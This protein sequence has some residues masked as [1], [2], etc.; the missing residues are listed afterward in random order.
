[1]CAEAPSWQLNRGYRKN[2]CGCSQTLKGTY[3]VAETPASTMDHDANLRNINTTAKQ[4]LHRVS[5]LTSPI[6]WKIVKN[7]WNWWS[8]PSFANTPHAWS[9]TIEVFQVSRTPNWKQQVCRHQ[10]MTGGYGLAITERFTLT[11]HYCMPSPWDEGNA[12]DTCTIRPSI[13]ISNTQP[14]KKDWQCYK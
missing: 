14:T 5:S 8:N 12:I 11:L 3:L 6:S 1:M 10:H 9:Y 4:A 13:D 7:V 2:W